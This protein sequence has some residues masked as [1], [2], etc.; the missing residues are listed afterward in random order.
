MVHDLKEIEQRQLL[1]ISNASTPKTNTV[2]RHYKGEHYIIEGYVMKESTEGI[3]V[4]YSNLEN[5]LEMPWSRP[6]D[7]WQETVQHNGLAISRFSFVR[8]ATEDDLKRVAK[9]RDSTSI[10]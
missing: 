1:T 4:C 9:R 10:Y 3:E 2:W 7:E 8:S 6:L 5:P